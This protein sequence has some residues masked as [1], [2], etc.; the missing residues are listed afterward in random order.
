V[1]SPPPLCKLQLARVS[2][3]DF[4]KSDLFAGQNNNQQN[5]FSWVAT[6]PGGLTDFKG[7]ISPLFNIIL[8]L[9]T[10]KGF[11]DLGVDVPI[12]GDFLGYVGF[13]T[14]AYNSVGHV[15]FFVPK[16]GIDLQPFANPNS[17]AA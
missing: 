17:P 4:F 10:V 2:S 12:F 7:D 9:A 11:A 13:G 8:N 6:N 15:T 5:V 14:Q 16:L 3:A 1:S